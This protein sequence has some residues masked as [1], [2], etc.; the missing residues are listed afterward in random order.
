MQWYCRYLGLLSRMVTSCSLRAPR[1]F[2][3]KRRLRQGRRCALLIHRASDGDSS[4]RFTHNW[5]NTAQVLPHSG[6]W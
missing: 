3:S 1:R 4:D 5:L 2:F 6:H